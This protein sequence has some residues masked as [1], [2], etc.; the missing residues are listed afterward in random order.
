MNT[1]RGNMFVSQSLRDWIRLKSVFCMGISRA[2][3][4]R[5]KGRSQSGMNSLMQWPLETSQ[6]CWC[7][8]HG[9]Q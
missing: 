4:V 3:I 9:P 8:R 6:F 1:Q 7:R 5:G 2:Y